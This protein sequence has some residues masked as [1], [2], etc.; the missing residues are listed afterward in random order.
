MSDGSTDKSILEQEAVYIRCVIDGVAVNKFLGLQELDTAN[1]AG[2]LQAVN[3][4][5]EIRAS[6][7]LDTQKSKMININLDG[8]SVNMGTYNGITSPTRTL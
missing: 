5:L 6:I 7:S 1:A 8:A 2:V 3:W 4:V